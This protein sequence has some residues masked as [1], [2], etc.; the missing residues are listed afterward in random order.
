MYKTKCKNVILWSIFSTCCDLASRHVLCLTQIN[1]SKLI[2]FFSFR[3]SYF[4]IN[5]H[6]EKIISVKVSPYQD[7][8]YSLRQ[9]QS[10]RDSH[11]HNKTSFI[12][13]TFS[14]LTFSQAEC[15]TQNPQT[16]LALFNI[17]WYISLTHLP[18]SLSHIFSL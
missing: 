5:L 12:Y 16:S 14:P 3:Y 1:S 2:K 9:L 10:P 15:P 8:S 17:K 13:Y 4:D 7:E 6:L 11:M 18:N